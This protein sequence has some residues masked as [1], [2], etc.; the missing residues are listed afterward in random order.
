MDPKDKI[1]QITGGGEVI[2]A[3]SAEGKVYV[4]TQ[5]EKKGFEWCKLPDMNTEK[6]NTLRAAEFLDESN[7]QPLF[8]PPPDGIIKT[9]AIVRDEEPPKME[10][11]K[12]DPAAQK[13]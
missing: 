2:Y 9:A 13:K 1:I 3:L 11:A 12:V 4:G 7:A 6:M 8:A 10:A 5:N